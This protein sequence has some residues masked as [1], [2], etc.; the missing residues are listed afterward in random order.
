MNTHQ[1][2]TATFTLNP[3]NTFALS[4]Y[5]TGNGRVTSLPA[6]IDCGATC[7]ANFTDGTVVTATATPNPGS[8]FAGWSPNC[9][10]IGGTCVVTLTAD[11]LVTAT[12]TLNTYTL[13]VATAGNGS[14]TT[15]NT[16]P[17]STFTHGTLVTVTAAPNLGSSFAGWSPN[18]TLAGGKCVVTLTANTLVTATFTLNTYT[19]TVATAGNGSGT[20]SNTPPGSTFTYGTLVTVTATP[21][22][23]ST[24]AGWSGACSGIGLC[25]V[26]TTANTLVTAT[27]STWTI[28]L[29]IVTYNLA[30]MSDGIQVVIPNRG[31]MHAINPIADGHE[32]ERIGPR[33]EETAYE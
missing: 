17:G 25:V 14:G 26:T 11:T 10:P 28:Y 15:S 16:P 20:T 21:N 22:P 13:T 18:C 24:F 7:A 1:S 2:V 31:D 9:T 12:F 8:S 33:Y 27:F 23:G 6:G 32:T 4:V 3:P 30:T 29:P 5:R 19:L